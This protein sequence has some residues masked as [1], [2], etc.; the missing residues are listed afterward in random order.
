MKIEVDYITLPGW[1]TSTENIRQ[2][3]NLPDKAREY[4]HKIEELLEVPG[5]Q[6]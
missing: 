4:I 1:C 3:E 2:F 5:E 6:N